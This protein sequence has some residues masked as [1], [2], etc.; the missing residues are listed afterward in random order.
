MLNH[1]LLKL[2][3]FDFSTYAPNTSIRTYIEESDGSVQRTA[4]C[5]RLS[6]IRPRAGLRREQDREHFLSM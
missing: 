3:P 2:V 4:S 5:L 6:I 1:A